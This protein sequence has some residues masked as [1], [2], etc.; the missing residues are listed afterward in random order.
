[1]H[2]AGCKSACLFN[3]Q[4]FILQSSR[5]SFETLT[6]SGLI[7]LRRSGIIP[8]VP[9]PGVLRLCL[10]AV[11]QRW[12][13]TW[14][15]CAARTPKESGCA[16]LLYAWTNQT[17]S[18]AAAPLTGTILAPADP[19]WPCAVPAEQLD[20]SRSCSASLQLRKPGY[21]EIPWVYIFSFNLEL[22]QSNELDWVMARWM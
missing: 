1:M 12:Q 3:Y 14:A 6:G 18:S 7:L 19:A 15:G 16:V 20:G 9:L 11:I 13:D 4:D 2:C 8:S 5:W 17:C 22:K 10:Q 21:N